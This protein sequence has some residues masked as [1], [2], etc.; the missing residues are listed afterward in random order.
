MSA[1][2]QGSPSR[3]AVLRAA[4]LLVCACPYLNLAAA[5]RC[6]PDRID[7]RVS[8]THVV[9]GDTV[10]LADGRTLRFIGVDTP[11]IG[12]EGRP[13]Q[14]FAAEAAR[15]LSAL[16][17]AHPAVDLRYDAERHDTYRRVLAH[18]FLG[19]GRSVEVWLLE[20]GFATLLT[21]PPNVWNVDCYQA[22]EAQARAARRGIWS[23]PQY[24]PSPV[25]ELAPGTRGYRVVSG[26]VARVNKSRKALWL[27][28]QGGVALRIDKEDLRYFTERDLLG[29]AGKQVV[30]RGWLQSGA[31]GPVMSIRHPAALEG[32]H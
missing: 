5:P 25:A 26:R 17:K 32:L 2:V 19:D 24:Q 16:L 22:A 31:Q 8:V 27:N 10:K 30:A 7:A 23:L 15:D 12:H 4:V 21:V 6:A 3:V 20:Q 11:E 9:D 1:P 29:A 14:P 18:L 13:S 28:L